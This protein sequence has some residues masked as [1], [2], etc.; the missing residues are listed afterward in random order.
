MRL[1]FFF[2]MNLLKNPSKGGI[3]AEYMGSY[4]SVYIIR[5]YTTFTRI[6]EQIHSFKN[7]NLIFKFFFFNFFFIINFIIFLLI[8]TI[9]FLSNLPIIKIRFKI[10]FINFKK[11]SYLISLINLNLF[12]M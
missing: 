1:I 5:W 8:S 7:I 9:F 2:S 11:L 4:F 3:N 6:F 12:F 10:N